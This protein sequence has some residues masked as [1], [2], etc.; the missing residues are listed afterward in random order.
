MMAHIMSAQLTTNAKTIDGP[1]ARA[2]HAPARAN[3]TD[4]AAPCSHRSHVGLGRGGTTMQG[5][6]P[7]RLPARR[8]GRGAGA[9]EGA[10]PVPQRAGEGTL[11][12]NTKRWPSLLALSHCRLFPGTGPCSLNRSLGAPA[13]NAGVVAISTAITWTSVFTGSGCRKYI[14]R[15]SCLQPIMPAASA[16]TCT[17]APG[18]GASGLAASNGRT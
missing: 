17:T 3:G 10:R 5:V 16:E 2:P 8:G 18:G 12:A 6:G 14:S 13:L 15:P 11:I 1:Y 9:R 4:G 7:G